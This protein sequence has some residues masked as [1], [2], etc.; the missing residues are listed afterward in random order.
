MI[1][2]NFYSTETHMFDINVDE[3]ILHQYIPKTNTEMKDVYKYDIS[4]DNHKP[5]S[6]KDVINDL[7]M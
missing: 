1:T 3:S 5:V 7:L 6:L 2:L 4:F